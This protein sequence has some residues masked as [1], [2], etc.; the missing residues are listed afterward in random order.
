MN[1]YHGTVTV[2][3]TMVR[4]ATPY[5]PRIGRATTAAQQI[6]S[7]NNAIENGCGALM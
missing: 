3:P 1:G 2:S 6:T 7:T 4:N 5:T